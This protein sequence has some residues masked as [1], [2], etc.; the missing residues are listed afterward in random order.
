MIANSLRHGCRVLAGMVLMAG[1][2]CASTGGGGGGDGT[3]SDPLAEYRLGAQAEL[4]ADVAAITNAY[5]DAVL[6]VNDNASF[7][8][9]QNLDALKA[10]Y[11]GDP[12]DF[13]TYVDQARTQIEQRTDEICTTD[14]GD[15]AELDAQ[16]TELTT[17]R[18]RGRDCRGATPNLTDENSLLYLKQQYLERILAFDNLLA[19]AEALVSD[20]TQIADDECAAE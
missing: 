18:N 2:G 13:P 14:L 10:A 1:A 9:Q 7:T 17:Q 4:D 20:A 12:E 6:C 15:D 19:A 3:S 11:T 16:V 5:N 8:D